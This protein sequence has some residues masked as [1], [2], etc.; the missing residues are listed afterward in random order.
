MPQGQLP[1]FPH[2]FTE[3]TA[4]LAFKKEDKKVTYFNGLMPVFV[5]DEDDDSSFRM[6]TSQFC[7]NGF[8]TQ[9]EI[10]RAFGVTTVSVKRSVKRYREEGP[11]GFYKARQTRGA[12]VLTPEVLNAA[13]QLFDDGSQIADV[14][15]QLEIKPN[16]LSKAVKAGHL[17]KPAKKKNLRR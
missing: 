2:G 13:Q 12:A 4:V 14:A 5:H 11:S 9:A 10:A 16:T 17:H 1:F 3:I 7:A 15:R 8:V 6:I